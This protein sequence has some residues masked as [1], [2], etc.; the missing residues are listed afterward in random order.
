MFSDRLGR[1]VRRDLPP[2]RIGSQ[3]EVIKEDIICSVPEYLA[4]GPIRIMLSFRDSENNRQMGLNNTTG[5]EVM[6]GHVNLNPGWIRS[7]LSDNLIQRYFGTRVQ[8]VGKKTFLAEGS[9]LRLDF[10]KAPEITAL[11]VVSGIISPPQN[12]KAL[13]QGLVIAE[14]QIETDNGDPISF[15]IILGQHT[16]DIY[17]DLPDSSAPQHEKAPIFRC[18][19]AKWREPHFHACQ[20]YAVYPIPEPVKVKS[21]QIKC[22]AAGVV[23]Q[24]SD[25]I[26]MRDN[27]RNISLKQ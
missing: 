2:V 23:I 26:L 5:N 13:F 6:I 25:L 20:Y 10:S 27:E 21:L 8:S 9:F 1:K 7:N 11:G 4:P 16:S 3:G 15:P 18:T 14:I 22:L 12:R 19:P 24:I 17:W